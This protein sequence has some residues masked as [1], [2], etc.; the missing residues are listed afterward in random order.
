MT[1]NSMVIFSQ[2]AL[3]LAEANTI[4]K[5]HELKNLALTAADWAK[6]KGIGEEAV[7]HCKMYALEAEKKMGTMLKETE[8]VK[9]RPGPGRGKAGAQAL[10][11][12]INSPP[13]LAEL[14]LSK[15]E[16]AAAQK[17][18]DLPEELFEKVITGETSR[19][20]AQRR[21]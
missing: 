16:S 12:L 14:G 6:R 17:L 13:T 10:P 18:A 20:Q 21:E 7:N 9:N 1:E 8:R 4:Q 19:T 5:A 11:A 3:M 2:A 15:K